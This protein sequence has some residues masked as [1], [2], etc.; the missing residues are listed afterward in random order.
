M[1]SAN[2]ATMVPLYRTALADQIDRINDS[3]QNLVKNSVVGNSLDPGSE[4]CL[5]I[6]IASENIIGG[7]EALLRVSQELKTRQILSEEAE[8]NREI[9]EARVRYKQHQ[10]DVDAVVE[11]V[12]RELKDGIE[13]MMEECRRI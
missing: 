4:Q 10:S 6:A 1:E 11:R 8:V 9:R 3:F 13:E 5:A 12:R 2:N 7:A